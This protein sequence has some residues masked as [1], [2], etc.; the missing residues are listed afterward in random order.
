ML[1]SALSI[2]PALVAAAPAVVPVSGPVPD[3]TQVHIEGVSCLFPYFVAQ[4]VS[5]P[6]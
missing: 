4:M 3:P 2:L 1:V 6:H 5:F